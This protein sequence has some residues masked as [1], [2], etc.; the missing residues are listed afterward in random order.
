[1]GAPDWLARWNSGQIGFHRAS[2]NPNLAAH[3][4]RL[5]P[6]GGERVLV[7]LCGKSLDL[8]WLEQRGHSVVG[9]EFAEKAVRD[10]LAEQRR[11]STERAPRPGSPLRVFESGRVELWLGDF[12]ALDAK[13]DGTFPA[14]YDRA[15]LVAIEPTRRAEYAAKV[16]ELLA[17][18]G[19]VLLVGLEY[20]RTRMEGPPFT[21]ARAEAEALFRPSCDVERLSEKDVLDEEPRFRE[22][23]LD[24]LREYVLLLTRRS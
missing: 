1:M 15:A 13:R 12:F 19:R 6:I 20:D 18:R 24:A 21:V 14:I 5:L 9:V 3:A 16:V 23:G 22:R 4:A 17:P 10:F 8:V 11:P 2:V 7:P